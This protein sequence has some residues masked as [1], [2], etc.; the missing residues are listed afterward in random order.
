MALMENFINSRPRNYLARLVPFVA[1]TCSHVACLV[2]KEKSSLRRPTSKSGVL[3][4]SFDKVSI[5]R[6]V[7]R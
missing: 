2:A 5:L 1:R 4:K 6:D 3:F 7:R